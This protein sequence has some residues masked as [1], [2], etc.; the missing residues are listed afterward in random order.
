[1]SKLTFYLLL[2]VV[3]FFQSPALAQTQEE[4]TTLRV[5][6]ELLQID[7]VVTDKNGRVIENLTKDDFEL[8]EEGTPQEIAFFS[9]VRD[10]TREE[11]AVTNSVVARPP[12]T[13]RLPNIPIPE[14]GKR[15]IVLVVDDLHITPSNMVEVKKQLL[16][17]IRDQVEEG[18]RV[19]VVSTGGGLGYLQQLTAD[20]RVMK[21]AVERLRSQERRFVSSTDPTRLTEFQAQQVLLGDPESLNLAIANY[22]RNTGATR[23]S[24]EQVV[25]T[26][27]RQIVTNISLVTSATLNTIRNAIQSLKSVSGRKT[28]LLVTDGFL[29]EFRESNHNNEIRRVID[30][31]TRS[32]V[33]IYSLGSAGLV[34]LDAGG[35]DISESGFSDPTGVSLRLSSQALSAGIDGMKT[36]AE[37]TGGVAIYNTNDIRGGLQRVVSDNELYYILAFYP[38]KTRQ[39]GKFH[40]IS[41]R[42]KNRKDLVVRTRKGFFAADEKNDAKIAA[43]KEKGKDKEKVVS[44]ETEAL[45]NA[46][47]SILPIDAIPVKLTGSFFGRNTQSEDN[48][49]IS[50]AINL[51][52]VRFEK[53]SD[54]HRNTLRTSLVVISEDGKIV[55]SVDDQVELK[56]TEQNF[57]TASKGWFF[58][59]KTIL[60]KPGLYNL[61]FAVRDPVANTLGSA[62]QWIEI[63]DLTSS[64]PAMSSILLL[65]DDSMEGSG[66][67]IT[68]AGQTSPSASGVLALRQ[69]QRNAS[70][71]FVC[72]IFNI[73]GLDKGE[74]K[75]DLVTQIQ[76]FRDDLPVFTSPLR[77][78]KEHPDNFKRIICG[79]KLPLAGFTPG[80]YVLKLTAIE[81]KSG[82]QASQEQDF[83]VE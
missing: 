58:F 71:G 4:G 61:R 24:A 11:K 51:Q 73:P 42:V 25:R 65:R 22:I 19:A 56:F 16:N 54:R 5:G 7:A 40:K 47:Y 14:N 23:E 66:V 13:G 15:I 1:M 35:R 75:Y 33:A 64:K 45:Q 27:A 67:G 60:L 18:D 82:L 2:L 3:L 48:T 44:P 6:T 72:Y 52:N 12:E 81:R 83:T 59:S 76:I 69:F 31:A 30:A 34:A 37:E 53:A 57:E 26:T 38:E 77:E 50:L 62:S 41:I 8:L 21:I 70:L 36:L 10:L 63:P 74:T 46:L 78:V 55:R 43:K 80:R 32:G 79:A 39:D 28:L 9:V 29:L 49:V 20:R 17:F 68:E